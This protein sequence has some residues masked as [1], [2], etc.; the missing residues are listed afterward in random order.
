[1]AR[2]L[3]RGLPEISKVIVDTSFLLPYVGLRVKEV[4]DEVM[5]WLEGIELYYPYAMVPEL[6]GVVLKEARKM[7]LGTIPEQALRGLNSIMYGDTIHLIT[8]VDQDL[9]TTYDLIKSGLSDL[10]DAI[11]YATSR[12][13]GITAITVDET[14]VDFLKKHGYS[15]DKILL[16]T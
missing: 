11:L 4:S 3:R 13:T 16:L 7:R 6:I 1:M 9:S 5:D 2:R 8:P 15:T 14:L 12:R 10:F